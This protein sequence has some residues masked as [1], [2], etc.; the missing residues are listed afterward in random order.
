[1]PIYEYQCTQCGQKF[2]VR[3]A[4]G[5]E[6]SNLSCPKCH[7]PNPTKLFSSFF[8]SSSSVTKFPETSCPTCSSGICGLPPME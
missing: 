6:G 8:S 2:E 3:Q 5:E 7:A 4:L 1:M